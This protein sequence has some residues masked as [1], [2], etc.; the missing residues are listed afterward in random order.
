MAKAKVI[1]QRVQI[2][3]RI[4][5]AMDRNFHLASGPSTRSKKGSNCAVASPMDASYIQQVSPLATR[6]KEVQRELALTQPHRKTQAVERAI[7]NHNARV[8]SR[9]K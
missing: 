3:E 8:R 1:S 7:R 4:P 5:R 9:G 2:H 6:L